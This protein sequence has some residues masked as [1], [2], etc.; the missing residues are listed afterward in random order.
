M[1]SEHKYIIEKIIEN[2]FSGSI[3]RKFLYVIEYYLHTGILVFNGWAEDSMSMTPAGASIQSICESK[4][5][6]P[7]HFISADGNVLIYSEKADGKRSWTQKSTDDITLKAPI[8]FLYPSAPRFNG[9]PQEVKHAFLVLSEMYGFMSIALI[10]REQDKPI[11][12]AAG[13]PS[14]LS[15][16]IKQFEL[17]Y[18]TTES[19][20]DSKFKILL[21]TDTVQVTKSNTVSNRTINRGIVCKTTDKAVVQKHIDILIDIIS[22]NFVKLHEDTTR[23]LA[24]VS[25]T[26][27]KNLCCDLEKLFFIAD[28]YTIDNKRWYLTTLE[29][30]FYRP[31]S[32][33]RQKTL[34]KQRKKHNNAT[35]KH[36][37]FPVNFLLTGNKINR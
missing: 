5:F 9:S 12:R 17:N 29:T 16:L 26:T 7:L 32:A 37:I 30:E 19:V 10:Q 22:R 31:T 35:H 20:K 25:T 14:Y 28:Y 2:A 13:M 21:P 36:Q 1:L 24:F 4:K 18:P 6:D 34:K 23:L 11:I 8:E 3:K 27:Q 15:K 33:A